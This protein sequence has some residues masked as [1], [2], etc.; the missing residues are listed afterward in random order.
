MVRDV[1]A[2]V[3]GVSELTHISTAGY[4]GILGSISGANIQRLEYL[5][6]SSFSSV[7]VY[8][9]SCHYIR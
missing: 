2:C 4:H 3:V 7:S 5:Q 8:I 9:E 6:I 1:R